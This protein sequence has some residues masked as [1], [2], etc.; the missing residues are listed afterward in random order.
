[1]TQIKLENLC[2]HKDDNVEAAKRILSQKL[3]DMGFP[4]NA[5]DHGA[6]ATILMMMQDGYSIKDDC[7]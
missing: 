4:A 1:M 7:N 3:Q 6:N 2:F 5:A